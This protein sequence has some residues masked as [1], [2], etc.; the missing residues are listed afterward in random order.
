MAPLT[1]RKGL[2]KAIKQTLPQDLDSLTDIIL[3]LRLYYSQ[4]I[5][6]IFKSKDSRL[7][8]KAQLR[9]GIHLNLQKSARRIAAVAYILGV[10]SETPCNLCQAGQGAFVDCVL[11]DDSLLGGCVNCYYDRTDDGRGKRCNH[12]T[13]GRHIM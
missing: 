13:Q 7:Q 11:L 2:K 4:E 8:R 1:T 12:A 10:Q 9:P 3:S 5:H 6:A